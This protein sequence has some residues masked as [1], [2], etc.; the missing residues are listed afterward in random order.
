MKK[1]L[2]CLLLTLTLACSLAAPAAAYSSFNDYLAAAGRLQYVDYNRIKQHT[3]Q[4]VRVRFEIGSQSFRGTLKRGY[5]LA[6]DVTDGIIKSVLLEFNLNERRLA[7][8]EARISMAEEADPAFKTQYWVEMIGRVLH[9]GGLIDAYKLDPETQSGTQLMVMNLMG[10]FAP[11]LPDLAAAGAGVG[12]VGT[13][14]LSGLADCAGPTAKEILKAMGNDAKKQQAVESAVLLDAFYQRCNQRLKEEA[15]K[16]DKTEWQLVANAKSGETRTLFGAPVEQ[17]W[18]LRCSLLK[19]G[20]GENADGIYT[21]FMTVDITH[22]M[23]QFDRNFLWQVGD[24]LPTLAE[25][26]SNYPWEHIYDCW[27][28]NSKLEKHL[29]AKKISFV[30]P[31]DLSAVRS[32]DVMDE[33]PLRGWFQS[34]ED[35]WS[36]HPIWIVPEGAMPMIDEKGHYSFPNVEGQM[37]TT[38]HI[39]GELWDG[40][41]PELYAMSSNAALWQSV[42]APYFHQEWDNSQTTSGGIMARN[43]DI[44]RDLK[45]GKIVLKMGWED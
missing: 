29:Y 18:R 17:K 24:T 1:R 31:Y 7:S 25:I 42:D 9:G 28:A 5:K 35:F 38:V 6:D 3:F 13:W 44:F 23:S 36:L 32:G 27:Q 37:A 26:H 20:G 16:K 40:M 39:M 12:A 10:P 19:E 4:L 14:I 33:L 8:H 21:G 43:S 11:S 41:S 45:D 2:L 34:K 22:D 15:E 30:I